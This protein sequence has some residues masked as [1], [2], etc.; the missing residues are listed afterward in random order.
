M[1]DYKG[2][3]MASAKI[4]AMEKQREQERKTRKAEMDRIAGG[5]Q[6]AKGTA[7]AVLC[8]CNVRVALILRGCCVGAA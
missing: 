2:G 7:C 1:T 3:A 4:L 5:E 6:K 8:R